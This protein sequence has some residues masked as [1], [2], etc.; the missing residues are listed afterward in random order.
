M[1][2]FLHDGNPHHERV[3][4]VLNTPRL[5]ASILTRFGPSVAGS[6]SCGGKK[7]QQTRSDIH[8]P[9]V[10]TVIKRKLQTTG[11]QHLAEVSTFLL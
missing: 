7:S 11:W 6:Q 8:F 9:D 10:R 3:N 2:W 1:D 4:R 5:F